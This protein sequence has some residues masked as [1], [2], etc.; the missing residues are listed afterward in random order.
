MTLLEI[1]NLRLRLKELDAKLTPELGLFERCEI[2][3]EVLEIKE[4]LGEFERTV[5]EGG[6]CENC[7]G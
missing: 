2:Q 5:Q 3:D 6:E 1:S 7:S 4:Q